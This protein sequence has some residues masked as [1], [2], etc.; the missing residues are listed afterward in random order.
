MYRSIVGALLYVTFTRPKITFAINQVCQFMHAPTIDHWQAVKHIL[1]YLKGTITHG[2]HFQV[3]SFRLTA[4]SDADWDR[5]PDYR[6]STSGY[7]VYMGPHLI[8]W[9]AKK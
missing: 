8:S 6:R 2:L 1:R 4:F 9:S 3:G 7:C 5:N